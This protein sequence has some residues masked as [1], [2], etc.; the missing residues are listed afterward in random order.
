MTRTHHTPSRVPVLLAA[1][2]VGFLLLLATAGEATGSSEAPPEPTTYVVQEGDTLW[3]VAA[4]EYE[5]DTDIRKV[6]H[7]IQE[8]NDLD[9]SMV[10]PGQTL[11]IPPS[12]A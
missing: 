3:A 8:L 12:D 2:A 5:G 4:T 11:L 10:F 7:E 1:L 6:I 9:G